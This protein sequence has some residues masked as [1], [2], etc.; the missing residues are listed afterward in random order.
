MPRLGLCGIVLVVVSTVVSAQLPIFTSG[1]EVVHLGVSVVG[2][3]GALVP[4][5]GPGDLEVYEDGVP[6]EIRY[7]S[8]GLDRDLDRLPLH[9]GVLFDVSD[10]MHEEGRFAKTAAIRFLSALD[11]A[12]DMTLVDFDGEVRVG[13]Y[14]QS[15]FP[16]LVERIRNREAEGMTAFYDALGVYLDGAFFQ[17]GRKV[18]LIYSDGSDTRSRMSFGDTLEL[19]RASDVTIYAIGFQKHLRM[20]TRMMQRTRLDEITTTTGGRSF[21]PDDVRQLESIYADIQAELD[22]RYSV[23]FVSSNGRAD[24][25]WRDVD[26]RVAPGRQNLGDVEIRARGGYY[27]PY[28]ETEAGDR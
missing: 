4:G 3:D 18:L 23:G 5:L 26:V 15:E 28:L 11:Y 22:G 19:V 7:F 20:S 13:R 2:E 6:Q 12:E 10:S 8:R 24:G 14:S 1:I 17:E 25:T 16:R 9:L 21:F 27:A